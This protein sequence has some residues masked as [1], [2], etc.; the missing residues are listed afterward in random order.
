MGLLGPA[1]ASMQKITGLIFPELKQRK[2]VIKITSRCKLAGNILD[3]TEIETLT[4]QAF[5]AKPYIFV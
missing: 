5:Q 2:L 1:G 3:L 4:W